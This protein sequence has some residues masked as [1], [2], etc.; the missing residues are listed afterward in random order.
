MI[1]GKTDS[2]HSELTGNNVANVNFITS[3]VVE[4]C[5]LLDIV[6]TFWRNLLP[7]LHAGT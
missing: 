3:I 5:G 4:K 6:Q 7:H 2:Q 1:L